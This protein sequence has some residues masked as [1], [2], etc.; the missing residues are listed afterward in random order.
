MNQADAKHERNPPTSKRIVATL[1]KLCAKRI[2]PP[3]YQVQRPSTLCI[4]VRCNA[5]LGDW[6]N[7]EFLDAH[8]GAS[9]WLSYYLQVVFVG[10]IA[11]SS[12]VNDVHGN[13]V[14]F[15]NSLQSV[16]FLEALRS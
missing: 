5:E 6:H 16:H 9:E 7:M 14:L 4:P 10:N 12:F 13:T 11:D 2:V 8:F 1:L 15:C 3:N